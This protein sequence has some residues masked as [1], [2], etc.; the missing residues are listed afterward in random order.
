M[1]INNENILIS[2]A[3]K[4]YNINLSTVFTKSKRH[5]ISLQEAFNYYLLKNKQ[6]ISK[7]DGKQYEIK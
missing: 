3:C 5:N 1:N 6:A 4:L 7:T 2:V